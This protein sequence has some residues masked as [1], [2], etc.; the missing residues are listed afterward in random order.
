MTLI[1]SITVMLAL[2]LSFMIGHQIGHRSNTSLLP[3]TKSH[4]AMVYPKLHVKSNEH[5]AK[6]SD[7]ICRHF[8]KIND[9][10]I[11]NDIATKNMQLDGGIHDNH[12]LEKMNA[13]SIGNIA[14]IA[15]HSRNAETKARALRILQAWRKHREYITA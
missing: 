7:Y 14:Y 10:R 3:Y 1:I 6:F 11:K 4:M 2:T 9:S 8:V 12:V 5:I 13:N 15:L